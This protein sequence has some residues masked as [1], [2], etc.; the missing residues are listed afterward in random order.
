MQALTLD[1]SSSLVE[2]VN[3]LIR[4]FDDDDPVCAKRYE[5]WSSA[6]NGERTLPA[7]WNDRLTTGNAELG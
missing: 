3:G 5:E 6:Q 4:A 2:A 1:Q 7:A